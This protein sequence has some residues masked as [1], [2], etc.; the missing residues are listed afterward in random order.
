MVYSLHQ[1]GLNRLRGS[2]SLINPIY[3]KINIM[4]LNLAFATCPFRVIDTG[5][6]VYIVLQLFLFIASGEV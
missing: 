1:E 6:T 3:R 5:I 4:E 2:D